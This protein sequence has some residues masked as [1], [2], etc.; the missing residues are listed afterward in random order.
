M[1]LN[2]LSAALLASLGLVVAK[3]LGEVYRDGE[4]EECMV[5]WIIGLIVVL[6]VMPTMQVKLVQA[7]MYYQ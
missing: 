7:M 6:I 3:I 2:V 5:E 1:V 4:L